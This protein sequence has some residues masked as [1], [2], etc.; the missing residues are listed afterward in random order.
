MQKVV[1]DTNVLVSALIQR[2][3][4]YLII[5]HFLTERKFQLCI[6]PELFTEYYEVL[7]RKKFARYPDFIMKAETLL[8]DIETRSVM[9][10]PKKRLQVINDKD[11]NKLLELSLECRAGFL[12][13][14][15]TNDFT[16]PRYKRTQI[17]TPKEYWGKYCP[18]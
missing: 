4:P 3:Y 15:N 8:A 12:I 9:F 13:T 17:V 1:V 11:D 10:V 16:I 5:N 7:N 2:S 14:G 18:K 6:S